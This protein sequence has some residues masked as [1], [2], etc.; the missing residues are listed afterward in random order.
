M[1]WALENIQVIIAVAGVI[2]YW[3]A[4][5]QRAQ[6]GL[7]P[8]DEDGNPLPQTPPRSATFEETDDAER[9]RQVQ[10]EIRRKIAERRGQAAPPPLPRET[11]AD[12]PIPAPARREEAPPPVFQ[13]PVAEMLKE[14]QKRL[15]PQPEPPPP[16]PSPVDEEA[17]A[18]QRALEVK[19]QALE[20][21][22]RATEEHV[23][24][25]ATSTNFIADTAVS[26]AGTADSKAPAGSW[27]AALRDPE[28]A[29]RAIAL[30][31]I[32]GPPVALR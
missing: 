3:L 5:R 8:T 9:A 7:P 11:P 30:R 25:L 17:L 16:A 2:A 19:M 23:A 12:A 14:I 22:R 26:R 1:K 15:A 27:L 20:V 6:Q 28:Q 31:E 24:A 4:Q 29:R 21:E 18:R 10:E 13:D 32:L